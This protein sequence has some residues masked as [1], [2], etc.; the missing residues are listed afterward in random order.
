MFLFG[1]LILLG[2]LCLLI[3][4]IVFII[5]GFRESIAWGL[6]L[7]FLPIL[8]VAAGYF[9]GLL[10][11]N[12]WWI[13]NLSLH[14]PWV[15]FLIMRWEKAKSGFLMMVAGIIFYV[16]AS[17]SIPT[18]LKPALEAG[19]VAQTGQPVPPQIAGWLG[20]KPGAP[21]AKGPLAPG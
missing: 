9:L 1:I 12:W 17:F 14:I 18:E 20:L 6:I 15:V 2:A 11:T 19:I 5:G 10:Q 7:L 13:V 4:A 3:G 8:G 16:A 21:G